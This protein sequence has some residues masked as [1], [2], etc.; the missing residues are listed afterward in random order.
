MNKK[1][2]KFKKIRRIEEIYEKAF[3]R[4]GMEGLWNL[5]GII[6]KEIS[7]QNQIC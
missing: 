1:L 7:I 3:S 4:I 5:L 6:L 2:E